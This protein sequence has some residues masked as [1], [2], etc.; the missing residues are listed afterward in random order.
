LPVENVIDIEE[1]PVLDFAET[2]KIRV[3]ESGETYAIDEVR[4]RSKSFNEKHELRRF[5]NA[6][7]A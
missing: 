6:A 3:V 5:T 7:D 4:L 1:N 2:F